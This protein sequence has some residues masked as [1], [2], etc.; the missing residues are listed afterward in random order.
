MSVVQRKIG[1]ETFAVYTEVANELDALRA[2]VEALRPDAERYRWLRGDTAS[3]HSKRWTQWE[4]R[5]WQAP[6]WTDDLRWGTL[7]AAVD[8]ALAK[9]PRNE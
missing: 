9:E 7:D 4:I 3:D 5:C 2:E 8:T 1:T 6:R